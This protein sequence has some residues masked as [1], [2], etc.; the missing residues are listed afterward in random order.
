M[1]S[2][3]VA[4][5][6]STASAL[7]APSRPAARAA[8]VAAATISL[9]ATVKPG[10]VTGEALV[11]LLSYAKEKG[12]AIPAVNAVSSCGINACM[13]AAAKFGGPMI[14]QFSRG[15]GQFLAGKYIGNQEPDKAS[16]AG[17]VAGALQVRQLAE[18]YGVPVILHTDHCM[19]DWLP[20]FDGLLEV[21]LRRPICLLDVVPSTRAGRGGGVVVGPR[22]VDGVWVA[23]ERHR[24][25]GVLATNA[26]WR[27]RDAPRRRRRDP[28]HTRRPRRPTRTTSRRTA[29]PSS[30]RTCWT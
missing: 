29:S 1:Q 6:L 17:C 21:R 28:A 2:V 25:D 22:R 27:P 11:D 4:L 19:R 10:V 24:L 18:L 14:V 12:F 20:W 16:V 7:V 23:P 13:E 8:P 3:V 26:T 30:R 5:A 9:P 15:G